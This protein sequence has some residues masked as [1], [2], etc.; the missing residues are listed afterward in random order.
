MGSNM[1]YII[2][3][4]EE[5]HKNKSK[6][7]SLIADMFQNDSNKLANIGEFEN[8]LEFIFNKEYSNNAFLVLQIENNKLISMINFFE[9][10]NCSNDWC[11]FTLF[12]NKK[13][14]RKGYGEKILIYAISQFQKYKCNKLIS[15]IEKENIASIKLHEKVG[16]KYVN[17][18]W[19]ELGD[20]FP[21]NHLGFIYNFEN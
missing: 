5:Y 6:Y 17:C 11:L 9:Y 18:N 2:V 8:H 1:K 21:E 4:K 19:D 12:T 13:M 10:N 16:F 14:R 20:G 7:I 15:G 3:E